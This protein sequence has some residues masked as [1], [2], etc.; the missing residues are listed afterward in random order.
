MTHLCFRQ[1]LILSLSAQIRTE[2]IPRRPHVHQSLE[3]LQHPQQ[4]H[5]GRKAGFRGYS[6][7]FS[8]NTGIK[9]PP[10]KLSVSMTRQLKNAPSYATSQLLRGHLLRVNND[11]NYHNTIS[12]YNDSCI[13]TATITDD[14][15]VT[16][17]LS[18]NGAHLSRSSQMQIISFSLP[19]VAKDAL[20]SYGI[21][22]L[23]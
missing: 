22:M 13:G 14:T 1:H 2:P 16:V 6:D 18:G 8:H 10:S 23:M 19:D 21:L 20:S 17:K 3:R 15:V 5:Q 11:K 12:N 4:A 7:S 9:M